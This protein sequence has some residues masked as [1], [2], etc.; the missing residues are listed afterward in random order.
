[1]SVPDRRA[2]EVVTKTEILDNVWDFAFA[3]D[4]N[5]VESTSVISAKS[6]MSPSIVDH[7]TVRGAGYRLDPTAVNRWEGFECGIR[8][9][10]FGRRRRAHPPVGGAWVVNAH[11]VSLINNIETAAR[12]RA[13][14]VATT[15]VGGIP[16]S[17]A[18]TPGERSTFRWLTPRT[19]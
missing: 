3:G 5:I 18:V 15:I 13:S 2:G 7:Q 11:R 6:S 19:V 9:T 16:Q 14:D 8:V 1:V 4:P 12:L 10:S 17:L